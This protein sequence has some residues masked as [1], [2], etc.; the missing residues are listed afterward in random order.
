M[1]SSYQGV[2]FES[3]AVRSNEVTGFKSRPLKTSKPVVPLH[4]QNKKT[5]QSKPMSWSS[6]VPVLGVAV[7]GYAFIPYFALG[8][9]VGV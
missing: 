9:A 8:L 5:S 6:L 7:L 2:F 3:A 4:I 1:T